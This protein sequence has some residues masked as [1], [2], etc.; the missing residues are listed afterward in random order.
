MMHDIIISVYHNIPCYEIH[1]TKKNTVSLNTDPTLTGKYTK[2]NTKTLAKQ[3]LSET[4]WISL[5]PKKDDVADS[6][7]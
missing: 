6:I 1:P 5:G 7:A 4:D 3:F 2:K